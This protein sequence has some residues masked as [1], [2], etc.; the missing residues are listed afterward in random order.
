M[1]AGFLLYG[2]NGFV[3]DAIARLA[4]QQ[5]LQPILAGRDAA[6]IESQATELGVARRVFGLDD[7]ATMDQALREVLV[8]LH[9]AGPYLYTSKPMV[10]ACLR[11]GTHYLDLT[12]EI[13]VYEAIAAR[14]AEAKAHG[15]ML[16]PGVGFDVAPTDCLAMHLKQR[17]PSATRLTLA[18]YVQ[19]PAGLPPGTQRTAIELVPY[20]NRVRRHGRLE[21]PERA[22]KTR[23]I[24]FGDGPL[25]AT[26]LTWG[27]V[28][29]AYYSTGIP[30]IADYAVLPKGLR[31]QL[32]AMA[33]LRPLFKWAAIRDLFKRGV[34]PGPT[35]DE[36]AKTVTHVWGEVEDDQGRSA[37]SRSLL[38]FAS[39]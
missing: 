39:G 15:V 35:A 9:C 25:P 17:L 22:M 10:E 37:V 27:D 21:T 33:A 29:T 12:G 36:R 1:P 31:R 20:G 18:F 11:T 26:Q 8:V 38:R 30:N 19:G 32:A 14:H 13:P 34:Q 16:L 4:V 5:G 28:F 2:A 6:K 7:S 3:G 24:D 23:P